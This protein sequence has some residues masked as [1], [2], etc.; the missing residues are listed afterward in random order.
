MAE[1]AHFKNFAK[2][3][4]TSIEFND[5]TVLAGKPGTGKSY[6][7]KCLYAYDETF[8]L[9]KNMQEKEL[10]LL[11]DFFEQT[12][13]SSEVEVEKLRQELLKKVK[14]KSTDEVFSEI[15][16]NMKNLLNSIFTNIN[17]ISNNFSINFAGAFITYQD[18]IFKMTSA[19]SES[20]KETADEVIFVETPLILEFHKYLD[21]Y[22]VTYQY[23]R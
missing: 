11:D 7:M 15:E 19:F 5:I 17:Q 10:K 20:T 21:T 9:I 6:V 4:D 13:E 3:K 12:K 2:L 18:E 14:I 8:S 22:R 23:F 16:S 1:L